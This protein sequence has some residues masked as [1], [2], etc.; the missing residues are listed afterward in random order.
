MR[1][2]R[3]YP[4]E[5]RERA[6]RLGF[7]SGRPIAHIAQDLGVH[8]E[9]LRQWVRQAE[10]AQGRPSDRP[11]GA[12]QEELKRLRK[13]NADLRRTGEILKA[14]SAFFAAELDRPGPG[15]TRMI[16]GLRDR[17]GAWAD[18]P[19]PPSAGQH[20]P[21]PQAALA[22]GQGYQPHGAA[23]ADP[24][25]SPGQLPGVRPPANVEATSPR[26]CPGRLLHG[27]A[28]DAR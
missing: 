14:A 7:E 17:F 18:L 8:R 5:L 1:A 20:L 24:P 28:A 26:R 27:R 25:G 3:K 9:A 6:V 23:G 19:R 12:E 13:E 4:A 22:V 10:A 16:D 21:R 2:P 15:V 11:T